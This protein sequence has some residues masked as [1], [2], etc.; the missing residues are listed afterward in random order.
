MIPTA[1]TGK[2]S[3]VTASEVP[4]Q[5][6]PDMTT[7]IIE[8]GPLFRRLSRSLPL[9]AQPPSPVVDHGIHLISTP[10]DQLSNDGTCAPLPPEGQ[11]NE[12]YYIYGLVDPLALHQTGDQLLSIFYVGKGRRSR[13]VHH[14]KEERRALNREEVRLERRSSKAERIR[15]ILDRGQQV[16]AIRLSAGYLN[17][18]D[19]YHAEALAIDTV[20]AALAAAGRP[21]L[22]NATPGHH[23][24][25][26][27]LGEHFVFTETTEQDVDAVGAS[28]K[29]QGGTEIF[30]KG[31]SDSITRPGQRRATAAALPDDVRDLAG[32]VVAIDFLGEDHPEEIESR[33]WDPFDPWTDVEARERARR[34][35]PIA[36][37]R[38]RSWLVEPETLP[39]YLLLGIPEP[40]GRT[41]VRYAW[42]IDR[43]GPWEF[44]TGWGR[45]G[46]PLS[47][48][49]RDHPR[50]GSA[51]YETKNGRR[52]Q[53]LAGYAS[54]IRVLDA[55]ITQS[56]RR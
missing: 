15:M 48:R 53:V 27:W 19:A 40:G 1:V 50:L 17:E 10:M 25:F 4:V 9:S 56:S 41:V 31:T 30:V 26:V 52:Q 33:G 3:L 6:A 5:P 47:E 14:E 43:Q 51:L 37:H 36:A 22:T 23:A 16:P 21:Q 28:D 39:K 34:Y 24:G 32:R 46:V 18:A 38:I 11:A 2:D 49:V 20:N 8:S 29:G 54:G 55:A 12:S 35:W 7:E 44:Y 42:Q 13:W 45:W